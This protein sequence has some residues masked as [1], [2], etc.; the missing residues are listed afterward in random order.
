L[1]RI[2]HDQF[3]QGQDR[4]PASLVDVRDDRLFGAA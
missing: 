1:A 2:C 3:A 4:N